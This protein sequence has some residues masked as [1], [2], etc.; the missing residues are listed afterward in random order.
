M[1]KKK[2]YREILHSSSVIGGASVIN[3]LIGLL[4]M[5]IIAVLLGPVGVGFIGL[6]QS[7]MATAATISALGFGTV[8]TRQIAEAAG[9]EDLQGI[10]AA[11]RALFW[12]T[13]LLAIAGGALFWALRD[14]V[15][16]YVLND[17]SQSDL[18]GW[19]AIGVMLTVA[20]GSQGALLRGLRRVADI[21]RISVY[22]ALLS[23]IL[24]IAAVLA[25]GERGILVMILIVP[26]ASFVLGHIYVAKLDPIAGPATPLNALTAQWKTMARIGAAFMI[27]GA[28]VTIGHLVVRTMIQREMGTD[29][30]GHFQAA[31]TIAMTYIGFVLGAMGTDYYPRLTA[32]IH[33]HSAAN[34]LANDQT[35][36]ALL[37]AGPVLLA[38]LGLAPWIIQLLYSSEFVEAGAIL[39]WQVLGDALKIASWPLGF[40]TL[41]AGASRTYMLTESI[42]IT[43]FV[44]LTWIGLP[45][46]GVEATGVAFLGMYAIYLP[47]VYWLAWRRTGFT[48]QRNVVRHLA[49]LGSL[50]VIIFVISIQSEFLGAVL[51]LATSMIVG[52]YG[53]ARLGHI[54]ELGG[55]I[56]KLAKIS[57]QLMMKIGIY[58]E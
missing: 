45:L 42:A 24:G 35:E 36:V 2:S 6:L 17:P 4:R 12:G 58:R 56:G 39:R 52:L 13:M 22:S 15:A 54:A 25:W 27:T 8:G 48:W 26:L 28:I 31:W 57:R 44:T 40:I 41:A 53:L 29:S 7:L 32:V 33:D 3:I 50:T 49:I 37:L 11:R 43:T 46:L 16:I 38:M 5:K 10:A 1:S 47:L 30:V 18:V 20:S 51:G 14:L 21:A 34:Q 19:L 23:A 55:P 9:R